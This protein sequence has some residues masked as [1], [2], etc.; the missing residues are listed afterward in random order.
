MSRHPHPTDEGLCRPRSQPGAP[1]VPAVFP[2]PPSR[3]IPV[4][5]WAIAMLDSGRCSTLEPTAARIGPTARR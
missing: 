1:R 2:W 4:P 5:S 3:L